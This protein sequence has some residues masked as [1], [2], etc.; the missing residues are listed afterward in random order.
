MVVNSPPTPTHFFN[1]CII[2]I[3]FFGHIYICDEY[4]SCC[5]EWMKAVKS[6]RSTEELFAFYWKTTEE[7]RKEFIL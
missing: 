1:K 5:G 3:D 6:Q 2:I 7:G 4:N